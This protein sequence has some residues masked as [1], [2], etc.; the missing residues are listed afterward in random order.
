[1]NIKQTV[2]SAVFYCLI[3][4]LA[5]NA[6]TGNKKENKNEELTIGVMSSMDYLPLA[7]ADAQGYF[8]EEGVNVNLQKFFSANDRDAAIQSGN[9]DGSIIDYTGAALQRSGGVELFFTSQCDG[10]FE[11]IA[12]KHT[13]IE[14]I[15][16]LKGK[17]VAIAQNTVIDFCTAMIL[18]SAGIEQDEVNKLE[19]NKIPLRL[20]MLRNEKI[21]LTVLPDPFV[22]MAKDEGLPS[23]ITMNDLG[24][25]VTGIVFTKSAIDNKKEEIDAFYRAYN[26][27][28][29]DL[30][31]LPLSDFQDV[32]VNEVGFPQPLV[33]KVILPEYHPAQLPKQED[34]DAVNRWLQEKQLLP[35]DFD[36]NSLVNP[37]FVN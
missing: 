32:L 29:A 2:K 37:D 35:I 21:D 8:E 30:Q 12:G 20:E 1:M 16:E 6:C 15:D 27:A 11:L 7:V 22:T 36:I 5:L 26:R 25:H 24:Y 28:I 3:I 33:D 31:Q 19:I 34:L 23:I 18:K 4:S 10:T 9:L 14:S 13:N 17:N